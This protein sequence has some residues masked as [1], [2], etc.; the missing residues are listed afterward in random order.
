MENWLLTA[1]E[2]MQLSIEFNLR[3]LLRADAAA[4][5]ELYSKLFYAS[6][7]SPNEIRRMEGMNPITGGDR[8][9][10]QQATIPADLIDEVIAGNTPL[11][12]KNDQG[13]GTPVP[14]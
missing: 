8:F 13:N 2:R 5:G 12:G 4:R 6:A 1:P 14:E 7:I 11:E 9:Y 3:G 10:L